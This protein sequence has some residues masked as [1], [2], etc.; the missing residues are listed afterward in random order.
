MPIAVTE[1][2][3]ALRTTALRWA[4]THCPP[5][6]PRGVAEAPPAPGPVT[7]PPCGRR[8]PPRAG[9]ASTCP[10]SRAAR[11]SPWPSWPS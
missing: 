2:H 9:S 6:V 10:R 4:Q 1:D 7:C 5:A 11:A 8:W 3:E